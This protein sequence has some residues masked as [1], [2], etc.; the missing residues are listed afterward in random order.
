MMNTE[1]SQLITE[2]RNPNTMELDNVST[3]DA[4]KI[5]NE[6]DKKV[7]RAVEKELPKIAEAV[8]II[9]DRMKNQNGRLIYIGAGTSGRIGVLDA[10]ECP[11]TFRVSHE[12]VTGVMAGGEEAMFNA[13]E[14]SEDE[15][16]LGKTD[17]EK[18]TLTKADAV[19]GITAS[20]RTPYPIGGLN[21]ANTIG[22]Y[23]ISLSSNPDS[24]IGRVAGLALEVITGEEVLTG[25]TRLKAG[26]AHKMVLNMISTMVMVR[27]G[28]VYENLMVDVQASNHKLKD[29]A[30]RIVIEATGAKNEEVEA[31]LNAC[32]FEVKPAIVM[33]L[34]QCSTRTA[35]EKLN[36]SGG[37]IRKAMQNRK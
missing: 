28:K 31:A 29:R 5:I 11:P 13:V 20:G 15:E 21:Y 23:T 24:Q 4:L 36:N 32:N 19:I 34:N 27:M 17:L 22:A 2:Q 25:S 3:L 26:T 7:A 16:E 12:Q 1:I 14:I 37:D 35:V 10:S 33:L 6:E 30:K 9:F 18:I 8:D